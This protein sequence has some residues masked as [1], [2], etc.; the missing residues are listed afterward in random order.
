MWRCAVVDV[1]ACFVCGTATT[2]RD[3]V[4]RGPVCA[5]CDAERT[6]TLAA[7]RC[8]PLVEAL[9]M[10]FKRCQM[11]NEADWDTVAP[12]CMKVAEEAL[13]GGDVIDARPSTAV[14]AIDEFM[15][16]IMAAEAEA[17]LV[18]FAARFCQHVDDGHQWVDGTFWRRI[19]ADALRAYHAAQGA[20]RGT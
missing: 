13:R 2:L 12:E 8:A 19:A 20:G 10:I 18:E 7:Q 11:A 1:L 6:D 17:K 3:F 16:K 15:K 5:T 14:L 4:V 9:S